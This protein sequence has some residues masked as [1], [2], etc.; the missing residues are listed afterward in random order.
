MAILPSQPG[1][2]VSIVD[3]RGTAFQEFPDDDA[4][5]SDKVVSKYI[6]AT[7]GSEFRIRWELTSPWPAHT[8]LLWFYVD[9][10]CVGGVYCHQ[11][12]YG[13]VKYTD[14]QAG[15]SSI[16]D[17]RNFLHKFAFAALD[18]GMCIGL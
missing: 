3:S 9:S 6:E 5:H 12:K 17:G 1:I 11:R 2:K 7:S 4:E 13:R 14:T 18:I 15:A 10:K 16:V 8:L